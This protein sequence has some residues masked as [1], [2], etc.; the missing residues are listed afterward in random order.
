MR[1][2]KVSVY[3]EDFFDNFLL[4]I[5]S[6]LQFLHIELEQVQRCGA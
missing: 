4:I 1:K 2:M 3:L 6:G 5:E